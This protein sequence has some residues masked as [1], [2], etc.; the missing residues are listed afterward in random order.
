[1]DNIVPLAGSNQARMEVDHGVLFGNPPRHTVNTVCV[2]APEIPRSAADITTRWLNAVLE[3]HLAGCRVL[4]SQVTPFSEPG[5]TA[6][7]VDI[8]LIYDSARC[9]LPTRMIAKLAASNPDTRSLCR[10]FRHYERETAFY[11]NFRGEDL[12]FP[13]CFHS[14]FD[15]ASHDAVILLEHLAPSYSPAYSISL[16]QI[17]LAVQ[18]VAKLHARWWKDD[19]VKRQS[20]LVQ[21]DDRDHWRNAAQGAN[22]AI[23][24]IEELVGDACPR[25]IE[26]MQIFADRVEDVMAFI[27]TRPFTLMHSDYHSKQMFFPNEQGEGK[28]AVID[29]QFSVAGPGAFDVSRLINIGLATGVRRASE[30]QIFSEYLAQLE[31]LGVPGYDL[32]AFIIDHKV[33][34]LF[35]QLIN[36]IA[37]AQTDATLVEREC[38]EHGLD[39]KEVWLLRGEAMMQEQEVPAFLK[40]I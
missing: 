25:S 7:I 18:E 38:S 39:W 12:P 33:G 31:R 6:D 30:Q 32:N 1:M 10:T 24:L 19:F 9:P 15:P 34:I 40:A 35:T 36:F 11:E 26:A 4:G 13:R 2:A 28:F 27:A 17:R 37:L 22:A 29:F 20:A 21:L 8:S 3:D 16:D 23:T 5:Q 14:R